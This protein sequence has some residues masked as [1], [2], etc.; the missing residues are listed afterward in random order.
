MVCL[1]DIHNL[2]STYNE[3]NYLCTKFSKT[4][5]QK[6]TVLDTSL[7]KLGNFI[8]SKYIVLSLC[9]C[10][11]LYLRKRIMSWDKL[12]EI[13]WL[14]PLWWWRSLPEPTWRHSKGNFLCF[15][16]AWCIIILSCTSGFFNCA[17]SVLFS[18]VSSKTIW[19]HQKYSMHFSSYPVVQRSYFRY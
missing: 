1:N 6:H 16:P 18:V 4:L 7:E 12:I 14:S 11:F 13:L 10:I 17:F 2:E 5:I 3:Q 19:S 15:W 9:V 8:R